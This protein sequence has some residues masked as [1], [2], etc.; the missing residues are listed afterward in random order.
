MD[1]E[2]ALISSAKMALSS[3]RF[4][5]LNNVIYCVILSR[6]YQ[7]LEVWFLYRIWIWLDER[8]VNPFRVGGH[9]RVVTKPRRWFVFLLSGY[10]SFTNITEVYVLEKSGI[11]HFD[12]LHCGR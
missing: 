2:T 10:S 4:R 6:C 11:V 5:L 7:F 8:L 1:R 9:N 12:R 3:V